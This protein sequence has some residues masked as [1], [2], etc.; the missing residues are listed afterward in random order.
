[1]N[2]TGVRIFSSIF[3]LVGGAI[4]FFGVK[5]LISAKASESWPTTKGKIVSSSVDS[6]R[7]DNNGTTYHAEVLYEY[8]VDGRIHSS[9]EV[10]FGGY[11]SS[12]PSHAREIVSKYPA[13]AEVAV[14]YSPT[15]PTKSVL[16]T[17]ISGQTFFLPG[18]GAI[19]FLAGIGMF[20]FMPGV[21]Q[22][23]RATGRATNLSSASH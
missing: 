2:S 16:E 6:K 17:G 5:S 9:N 21:I 3:I 14:H 23:Q 20:I 13:G 1:M 22:R 7:S 4:L 19:F 8:G 10:A 18:F 11:S 15:S 12:D